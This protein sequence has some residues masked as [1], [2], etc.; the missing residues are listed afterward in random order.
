MSDSEGFTSPISSEQKTKVVVVLAFAVLGVSTSAVLV[1]MMT[2]S[3]LAIASW[4]TLGAF[5]ILSPAVARQLKT[6]SRSD[7]AAV[8]IA[9]VLL[10]LH[11]VLWFESLQHTT[12]LRSTVLVC[13]VPVWTGL[14]E[15]LW[16]KRR[17]PISFW[18]GV[19]VALGGVMFMSPG[20]DDAVS[21]TGDLLALSASILWAFY[22]LIG[23]KVRQR[24]GASAWMGIACAS[25]A[26]CLWPIAALQGVPMWGF[27]STTW[28]CLLGAILGPQLIGHQGFAY[29]VRWVPAS[30]IALVTLLEPVG[31]ATLAALI[32]NEWPHPAAGIGAGLILVGIALATRRDLTAS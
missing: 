20:T 28:W 17:V 7:L 11:F 23:R 12:V 18:L 25:S 9:G 21:R 31:A 6:I 15:M 14:G 5:G 4:R 19:C 16:F 2:A 30:T 32:L 3:S 1:K 13:T 8:V 24:V 27:D 10:G 29:A 22:M 26:L